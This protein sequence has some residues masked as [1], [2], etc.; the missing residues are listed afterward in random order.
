MTATK[1]Q[2]ARERVQAA[3]DEAR[4]IMESAF[5]ESAAEL[6]AKHPELQAFKWQQYTPYFNDG[7]SCEF[8]VRTDDPGVLAVGAEDWDDADEI[9]S[10]YVYR[11][12]APDGDKFP[13][14]KPEEMH[15]LHE[16]QKSVATFL[17]QFDE[18]DMQYMFGD[19]VEITVDRDD[20]IEKDEYSHD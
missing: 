2:E 12:D 18:D 6:F 16:A 5:N 11:P 7:D 17:S 20:G 19:H 8:S 4:K 13:K 10:D 14:K 9:A 15:Q 1:Y 3:R